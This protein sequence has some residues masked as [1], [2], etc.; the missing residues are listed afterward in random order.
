M[1]CVTRIIV[2]LSFYLLAPSYSGQDQI[3]EYL[4]QNMEPIVATSDAALK[5]II[6]LQ[7]DS[8]VL[9]EV[10]F[11]R[12]GLKMKGRYSSPLMTLEDGHFTYYFANG[13]KESEGYFTKGEKS[14]IWKR[15]DWEGK[16][17]PDRVYPMSVSKSS[18]EIS[19]PA[20]F[21]GGIDALNEYVVLEMRFPEPAAKL[22]VEGWVYTAFTISSSG[23]VT[24][25]EVIQTS[26]TTLNQ[27]A[28]RIV[29]CMPNWKPS[30]R[31][32]ASV[33]SKFILPIVF[34]SR[35]SQKCNPP[36]V[37]VGTR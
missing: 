23:E 5:R 1:M 33:D 2:F 15:W 37:S 22:G 35:V 19:V 18:E 20:A 28:K 10:T 26:H 3:V 4:D 27:E 21:P 14:G 29:K 11:L 6:V 24:D 9:V 8:S 31:N 25:I 34:D 7:E 16:A 32:G 36:T 12:G 17:K 30:Q 13:L